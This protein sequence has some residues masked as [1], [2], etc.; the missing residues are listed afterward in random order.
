[1]NNLS[2]AK[3]R[4]I[5]N[6]EQI[7]GFRGVGNSWLENGEEC[8]SI[9]IDRGELLNSETTVEDVKRRIKQLSKNAPFKIQ[10][11]GI[12]VFL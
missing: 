6:A 1:M 2:E 4:I 5:A 11:V 12:P 8:L 3:Q 7:Q 10:L 9:R